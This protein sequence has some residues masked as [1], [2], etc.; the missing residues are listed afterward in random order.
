MARRAVTT[1]DG[2]RLVDF[3]ERVATPRQILALI[4][5][6]LLI[7]TRI[8][9]TSLIETVLDLASTA[10]WLF[11]LAE[12]LWRLRLAPD[13]GAYFRRHLFD[14]AALVFPPLRTLWG[15]APFRAVLSRPGLGVFLAS[16]MAVVVAAAGLVFA[17]ERDVPGANIDSFGDA[18]WWAFVSATTVGYGDHTPVSGLGRSV[19]GGLI[20]VGVVL[21]SVVTAHITAYVLER[22]RF[23]RNSAV[24]TQLEVI[25]T[26]LDHLEAE[27][28]AR[29]ST[30][31]GE[32]RPPS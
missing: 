17:I 8:E 18:V 14:I 22:S 6:P 11:F 10:I 16:M 7:G 3:E 23:D 28:T 4:W 26:R 27:L 30:P 13:R 2:T 20:L 24:L 9:S 19:A 1:A 21:Y 32:A 5:L 29:R 15:L 25:A 12:Y 31:A